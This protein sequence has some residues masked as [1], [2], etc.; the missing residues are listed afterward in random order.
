M[1]RSP[2]SF[3]RTFPLLLLYLT[4]LSFSIQPIFFFSL[5][6][7]S[8]SLSLHLFQLQELTEGW[9]ASDV[10]CLLRAPRWVDDDICFA[11]VEL[12]KN[13]AVILDVR[14]ID[15]KTGEIAPQGFALV[16]VSIASHVLSLGTCL[17]PLPVVT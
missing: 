5:S 17:Y 8:L 15:P 4:F 11:D 1:S 7:L 2:L 10:R 3:A 13:A 16:P 14:S 6:N 12:P 9:V